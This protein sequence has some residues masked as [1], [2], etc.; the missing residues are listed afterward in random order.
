MG[1]PRPEL[2]I[3]LYISCCVRMYQTRFLYLGVHINCIDK[4][5]V[6][7]SNNKIDSIDSISID[8]IEVL[9]VLIVLTELIKFIEVDN[10]HEIDS[11]SSIDRINIDNIKIDRIDSI[12]RIN[13]KQFHTKSPNYYL[14]LSHPFSYR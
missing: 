3:K 10:I 1:K 9:T 14:Y 4:M 8:S 2:Y 6:I 12:D 13:N 11:I 5:C 7:Y